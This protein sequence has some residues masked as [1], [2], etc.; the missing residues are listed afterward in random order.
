[1]SSCKTYT[2]SRRDKNRYRKVYRYIRKKPKY[3]FVSDGDLTIVVGEAT[4]ASGTGD[5]ATATSGPV[6]IT[7]ADCD[8]TA[9]FL[10]IPVVTAVAVDSYNNDTADV[11]VFVTAVTT[12]TATF[13]TSAPFYGTV[14]FQII[15]RD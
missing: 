14:H 13:E 1:M 3:E 7:F 2:F 10:Q 9:V 5:N 6:E 4:F 11:N 8:P 15:G 12:T